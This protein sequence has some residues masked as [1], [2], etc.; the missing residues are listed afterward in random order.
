VIESGGRQVLDVEQWA[1]IRRMA[2]VGKLSQRE[3]RR[4]TGAGRDVR[5]VPVS[6]EESAKEAAEHGVPPE[7]VELLTYLFKEVVDG[8]NADVT[9]GVE[10]ALGRKAGDFADYARAAAASGVWSASPA[11]D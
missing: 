4:R 8:R 11:T 10:R 1:E 7:V 3:I 6:L 9:D 5:Y 2:L